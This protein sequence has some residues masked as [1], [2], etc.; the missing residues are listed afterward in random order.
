MARGPFT[1]CYAFAHT[2]SCIQNRHVLTLTDVLTV[3]YCL[4]RLAPNEIQK[5]DIKRFAILTEC[6]IIE[7]NC[8][9]LV[10]LKYSREPLT[11]SSLRGPSHRPP[12]NRQVPH[13]LFQ[14]SATQ[15][16]FKIKPLR[17]VRYSETSPPMSCSTQLNWWLFSSVN[18]IHKVNLCRLQISIW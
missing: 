6:N 2:F 18:K 4:G 11:A 3:I 10:V 8:E 12:C 5:F 9:K 7:W 1:L 14:N 15:I 16:N 13:V 17:G